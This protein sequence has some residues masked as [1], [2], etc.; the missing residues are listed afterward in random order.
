VKDPAGSPVAGAT[1]SI[2]NEATTWRQNAASNAAGRFT[3]PLVQPGI[4]RL[5]VEAAGFEK[6][7]VDD[8][9]I[10]VGA[11]IQRDVTLALGSMSQ[12][13]TVDGSGIAINTTDASVSTIVDRSPA[14]SRP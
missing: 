11:K 4:Y 13:V 1:A 6:A 2:Q 12:S 9:R 10:D 3:L 8:L 7:V 5:T 14:C